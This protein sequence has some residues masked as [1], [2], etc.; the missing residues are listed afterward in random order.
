MEL[1][2]WWGAQAG[3]GVHW[4]GKWGAEVISAQNRPISIT[5]QFYQSQ[6]Y[7][8]AKEEDNL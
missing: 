3:C 8:K 6:L 5:A 4:E 1:R 7:L 2:R